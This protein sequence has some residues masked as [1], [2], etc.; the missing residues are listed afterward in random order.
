MV[1]SMFLVHFRNCK[2]GWSV[3][4]Q[5]FLAE[6]YDYWMRIYRYGKVIHIT[7]NLYLYRRRIRGSISQKIGSTFFNT[8]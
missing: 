7:D 8:L 4:C 5:S 2:E 1:R 6:D 3:R